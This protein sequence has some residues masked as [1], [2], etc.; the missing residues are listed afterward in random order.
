MKDNKVDS[1]MVTNK[2]HLLLGLVTLKSIHLLNHMASIE[3]VMESNVHAV[4]GR[5]IR[6][7]TKSR[8]SHRLIFF[9]P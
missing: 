4:H 6:F 8:V 2:D 5:I 9:P 7:V 1:L 3:D